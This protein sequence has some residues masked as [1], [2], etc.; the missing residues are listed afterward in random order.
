[1][2]RVVFRAVR[3]RMARPLVS[4]DLWSVVEPLLPPERLRPKVGRPSLSNRA[5][6]TGILF[7]LKAGI[8]WAMLPEE[9]GCGSGMT[10]WR[11]LRDWQE[12]GVWQTLH[13]VLLD[14]LGAANAIDWSRTSPHS[15]AVRAKRVL[16]E[17]PEQQA[18][19]RK[20]REMREQGASLRAI[21]KEMTNAGHCVSH[22]TVRTV[23]ARRGG[24]GR[25]R[26]W[27]PPA[28]FK[29]RLLEDNASGRHIVPHPRG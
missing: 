5:A 25:I 15:T 26:G 2:K 24:K 9:M 22:E 6:L 14:R 10:C 19:I 7:V 4:D 21:A 18:A 12:A 11:R 23:L 28:G 8:P 29:I 20:M 17:A 3:G 27:S 13:R 16:V 1:M